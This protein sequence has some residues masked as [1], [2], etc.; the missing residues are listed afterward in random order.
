VSGTVSGGSS[1]SSGATGTGI[2][3]NNSTGLNVPSNTLAKRLTWVE[4]R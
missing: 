4:R 3:I 1:G 2:G